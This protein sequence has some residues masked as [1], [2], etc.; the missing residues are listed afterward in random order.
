[1]NEKDIAAILSKM[2]GCM[3]LTTHKDAVKLKTFS[4]LATVPCAFIPIK[5]TFLAEEERFLN[6]V[7]ES[8]KDFSINQ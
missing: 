4:Q 2:E 1:Y 6:M 7:E 8:L 3:L 5:V